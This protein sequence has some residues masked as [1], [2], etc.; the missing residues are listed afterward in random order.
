MKQG[1]IFS[2]EEL[3]E[4]D[5]FRNWVY[6][7]TPAL[8]ELWE[9]YLSEW[10][11]EK[12]TIL[13]AKNILVEIKAYFQEAQKAM[14]EPQ[15]KFIDLLKE[16]MNASKYKKQGHVK[17]LDR[18]ANKRRTL[19]TMA[20]GVCLC[21]GLGL[22]VWLKPEQQVVPIIHST[23]F[24]EWK[25]L[26][27]PDSTVVEL[28]ANSML[29]MEIPWKEGM[30]RKVLLDG[31]AFFKVQKK[32]ATGA[33]FFVV[34]KDL[35]VEVLGTSF[36]VLSRGQD[37]KVFLE[38]GKIKLDLGE[39]QVEVLEP[40]EAVTY[41]SQNKSKHKQSKQSSEQYTSWKDGALILNNESIA[42]IFNKVEEIYGVRI[43]STHP[44]LMEQKRTIMVPMDKLEITI[45][46]LEKTLGV[47]I[48]KIDNQL[49]I[50]K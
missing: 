10:P 6:D 13:T 17:M 24:G 43:V 5:H 42:N 19:A 40:G 4:D 15:E 21:L 12:Q 29:T 28:N 38:E 33:K 20:A 7:P 44:E 25:T 9:R 11:E 46:I 45:P 35:T 41:S 37:T 26:V 49:F 23:A 2:A 16:K 36:N 22:W 3:V 1:R 14:D 47:K 34:T 39:E 30:D 31:E 48:K 32:P 18:Q 27:L 50:E 8:D